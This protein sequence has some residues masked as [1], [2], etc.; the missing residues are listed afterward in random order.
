MGM[1]DMQ[2]MPS[3]LHK[4]QEDTLRT[5]LGYA[6]IEIALLHRLGM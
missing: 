4:I 5:R 1:A 2:K 3:C 6:T